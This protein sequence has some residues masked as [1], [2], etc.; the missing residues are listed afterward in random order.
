MTGRQRLVWT[1][2]ALVGAASLALFARF[3]FDPR[4]VED[5]TGVVPR[6]VTVVLFV[7]LTLVVWHRVAMDTLGHVLSRR[8]GP[9]SRVAGPPPVGLKVAFITTFV[10]GSEPLSM[11]R[12]TLTAMVAADYDHDTWVLDEGDEAGARAL[13]R[14]LGVKHFSRKGIS[15]YNQPDGRFAARTKGGNHNAWYDAHGHAYDVVAQI[16]TDF[17]ARRDFLTKTLGYF[18]DARTGWV[19]TP[20]IYGNTDSLVAQGAAQQQVTFYGPLL[21]ALSAR[22]SALLL[23]ANHVIRV[24]ALKSVG[25]YEGHI[26]EDLATGIKMHAA[27]W[28]SYYV[29]LPLAVGEGPTSWSAYFSQQARWAYGCFAVL[30]QV[31]PRAWASLDGGAPLCISGS[32]RTTS[33]AW[34]SWWAPY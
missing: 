22:G 27:G 12:A 16:D 30:F 24:S 19:V 32:N 5:A 29:P 34:P 10:P 9:A 3:W 31:T 28:R 15:R 2:S 17:I 7:L 8:M 11:L 23:G 14:E 25:W 13:C 4:R 6:W 26:T 18:R 33:A 1:V 20:Q 21:R